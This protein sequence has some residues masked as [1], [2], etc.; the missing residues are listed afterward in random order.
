MR[1]QFFAFLALLLTLGMT[2]PAEAQS[3]DYIKAQYGRIPKLQLVVEEFPEVL[4]GKLGG[5]TVKV[6]IANTLTSAGIPVVDQAPDYIYCNINCLK[7]EDWGYVWTCSIE[8]KRLLQ[9]PD[10]TYVTGTVDDRGSVGYN[11]DPDVLVPQLRKCV[12]DQVGEVTSRWILA[13]PRP[14]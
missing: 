3:L 6:W 1:R 10:G 5:D 12:L 11:T 4:K 9:R 13:N 2:L 14:R 7:V 8:V